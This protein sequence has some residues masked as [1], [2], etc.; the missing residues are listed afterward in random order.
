MVLNNLK[1]KNFIIPII[2]FFTIILGFIF[3]EDSLGGAKNDFYSHLEKHFCL[4]RIFFII[5]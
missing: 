4:N 2:L 5:L 3:N 1:L